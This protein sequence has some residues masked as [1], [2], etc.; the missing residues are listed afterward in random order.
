MDGL[1]KPPREGRRNWNHVSLSLG[2]TCGSSFM[3]PAH[4]EGFAGS[5]LRRYPAAD[6]QVR[7]T[8]TYPGPGDL[9]K[10]P[11]HH[12]IAQ[13]LISLSACQ[14]HPTRTFWWPDLVVCLCLEGHTFEM[15]LRCFEKLDI[16]E[17]ECIWEKPRGGFSG[18]EPWWQMIRWD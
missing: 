18:S 9:T 2:F 4:R 6:F 8:T 1:H 7:I 13:G 11:R 16:V 15:Q 3:D 17:L 10:A 14:R 12:P 5:K